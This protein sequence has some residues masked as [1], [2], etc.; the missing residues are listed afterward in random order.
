MEAKAV[1][2]LID[3]LREND[4]MLKWIDEYISSNIEEDRSWNVV[5][6]IKEFGKTIFDELY[7]THEKQ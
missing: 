4:P 3:S 7:K 6:E 2:Q 1:D 5:K